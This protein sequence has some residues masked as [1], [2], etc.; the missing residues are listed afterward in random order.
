MSVS[1]LRKIQVSQETYEMQKNQ[2]LSGELFTRIDLKLKDVQIKNLTTITID[3]RD[4]KI[5]R[6]VLGQFFDLLGM[7]RAF[8]DLVSSVVDAD[9]EL[10][11]LF[12]SS[13]KKSKVET[14][15]I[16]FNNMFNEITSVYPKGDKLI[17]DSQYF[18]TLEKVMAKAPNSYLRDL[19]IMQNG[20]IAAT[21]MNPDMEFSFGGFKDEEFNGGM[22][23]ELLNNSLNTS[24][25]TLRM[26]CSNGLVAKD[27]ICTRSIRSN[28]EVPDFIESLLSPAYQFKSLEEFKKRINR[29]YD[30]TASLREVLFVE[31]RLNSILGTGDTADIL[32][33]N[34][35]YNR[36]KKVFP[37]EYMNNEYLH[38]YLRTDM[39][40]WELVNEVT[41]ISSAI[42]QNRLKIP[43]HTN[44]NLQ[45][46][47]GDLCFKSPDLIPR[48]I[49]QLF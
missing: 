9:T 36:I 49:R 40:L 45:L 7:K 1:T 39:S 25:F 11:N 46:L 27:Q 41:A 17:T 29:I 5:G 32:T 10:L 28:S 26:V 4:I 33:G 19:V 15:T 42:E 3:N 14:I 23:L 12:I 48:S 35:C 18:D 2:I 38:R 22:T 24:F 37:Q 13:M 8:Y 31:K 16:L 34:M 44:R 20:N 21:I 43:D 6:A 30:T 47:G